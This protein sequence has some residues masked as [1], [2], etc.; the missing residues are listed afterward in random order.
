MY[1]RVINRNNRL[2]KLIELGAPDIIIRNEKRML[3]EAVDALIDNG[4]RGKAISGAGNRE[5]KSLSGL[6]RG[7][8]GRFRQNLLGK[9]VDYSGRSVIVVGPS[10]KIYQCGLPKEMALELFKPFVMKRLV[11]LNQTHNIKSAKRIVER[12]RPIV[13]DV[14]EDV[15]KDHPVLLNRAPTLHRLGIQAFEPVLVEGRAIK[16]HPLTC[17][18]FNADFDGDQMPIHVPLSLEA[19]AEA[20]FLMI[21]SNNILKPSDGEPITVP[22]QDMILGNYY[23]TFAK[24]G[25]KGE[26]K[27]FANP[28]EAVLAY[29]TGNVDLQAKV[30]IRVQKV[31]DGKMYSTILD[32][33][34]GRIIFNRE[35]PQN[36][37][38]C[39]RKTPEDMLKLEIDYPCGKK[40][41]KKI[42]KACYDNLGS[43]E[44][45]KMLDRI[46]EMGYKY[47]T[48]ACITACLFDVKTT[49]KREEIIEKA[50]QASLLVE[51]QYKRGL[52]T[53]YEKAEK[54]TD[55][56]NTAMGEMEKAV[57]AEFEPTNP[58]KMM[59]DSQARGN[60]GNMC[61]LAGL[62]GIMVSTSG[63]VIEVP[64]RSCFK[65]GLSVIEYFI[66]TRGGRKGMVD[67]ALKTADAGY[68]TRRLVDVAQEVVV[69]D[70]DCFATLGEKVR[71]ME[72]S[73][74]YDGN[75]EIEGLKDR[76]YGRFPVSDVIHPE[77][78]EVLAKANEMIT[79]AQADAIVAAGIKSVNI[80]TVFTCK[81]KH[82][83]CAN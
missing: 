2:K 10:L 37:G 69:D 33:T 49:P 22:T 9:R 75:R 65:S 58:L 4:R 47:S 55:A 61:Q 63:K 23:L 17:T 52:I 60:A 50:N 14:L 11:D 71:G 70:D 29:N 68:L 25:A 3:Q 27:I 32:T 36:L 57:M 6:L 73:A 62:R 64:I 12:A 31:I 42:I 39:E 38:L 67:K 26:G 20:R 51:K 15:I 83:V 40:Q 5:L 34:V 66:A 72:V 45:A 30:K 41:I 35:I 28:D 7:K 78:G 46:K 81:S 48:K 8:Q 19:Q 24:E 80:R 79:I 21:A 56:W 59:V 44:T 77:T 74:I 43:T 18:A 54:L 53:N 16:L 82:G 1:R 13:W 76:I